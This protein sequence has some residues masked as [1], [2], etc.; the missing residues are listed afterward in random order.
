[1]KICRPPEVEEQAASASDAS[2]ATAAP[3]VGVPDLR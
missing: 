2:A 3:T 1:M